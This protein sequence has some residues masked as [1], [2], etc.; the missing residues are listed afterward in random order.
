M[1]SLASM[2]KDWEGGKYSPGSDYRRL[3]CRALGMTDDELFGDGPLEPQPPLPSH[4]AVRR[5]LDDVLAG[6][7][8]SPGALEDWERTVQLYGEVAREK[9]PYLV[10]RDLSDDLE[11]L[12]RA[13]DRYRS[14]STLRRLSRV[15]AQLSGLMCLTLIKLD[16]RAG[17]RR[18]ART[19]RTAAVEAGDPI[20][21]SWVLAQEAYGH[22]YTADLVDAITVAQQAQQTAPCSVGAV[23]AAA[24][25]ARAQA[26][27]GPDRA[28]QARA[29]LRRAEEILDGL[30]ADAVNDSAFGYNEAQLRFH[31]GNALTYLGNTS[32]AWPV[33]DRAL[34]LCPPNNFLDRTLTHLDRTQ[35]LAQD[36]DLAGAVQ[37]A[38]AALAPVTDA[39]RRGIIA[40]RGE[41]V[42][43]ALQGPQ[44]EL[45][46][47]QQLR[48][49][50][51]PTSDGRGTE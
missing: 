9:L 28:R 30:P 4:D 14:A 21:H 34:V 29:S 35:C 17:F 37:Y 42:L 25:E 33:Q 50:L 40:V 13:L 41:E 5:S 47:A 32:A 48:E 46:S 20:T 38:A 44:R 7:S 10:A 49:L 27:L 23:L 24:L 31:E 1:E 3:Y 39:Q 36:G 43:A 19:A 11:E 18:W 26:A 51:T 22:F 15:A 2:I 12:R 16:E 6:G 8:M 45:R